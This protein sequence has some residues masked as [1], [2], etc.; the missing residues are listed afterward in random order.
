MR[1][2]VEHATSRGDLAHGA[3]VVLLVKEKAGFLALLD[4][5]PEDD[6]V[7]AHLE[8][9]AAFTL[10]PARMTRQPLL[11]A[12]GHVVSLV[13][14][15]YLL[16]IGLQDVEQ[17]LVEHRLEALHPDGAHLR[18]EHVLVAVDDQPRQAVRFGKDDS[19]T[20]RVGFAAGQGA[21]AHACL[22]VLPRPGELAAPECLVEAVV[23]VARDEAD[24][25]RAVLGDEARAQVGAVFLPHVDDAAVFHDASV[26]RCGL[27]AFH[28]A[29]EYPGVP[30]M[31]GARGFLRDDC[32]GEGSLGFHGLLLGTWAASRT[33]DTCIVA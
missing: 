30:F 15:L 21:A 29:C 8:L 24:T 22:A 7:F 4:V 27:D 16:A 5:K 18:D 9:G 1:E 10:P 31:Y 14:A 6:A 25:D 32:L 19:A 12:G 17:Q 33:D 13:D 11:V 26:Q 28:L 2:T 3:A 20:V 23:G